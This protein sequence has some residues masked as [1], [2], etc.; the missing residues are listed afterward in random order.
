MCGVN[1][2]ETSIERALGIQ[3]C[4][5]SDEFQFCISIPAKPKTRR[6]ILST[7]ASIYDPMGYI[8]P[9]TLVG[10]QILQEMCRENMAWDE[11]LSEHLGLRWD[12]WL[13]DLPKLADIKIQRH[14]EPKDF[15]TIVSRELHHF[16]DASFS[17][18]GQC[19][20]LRLVNDRNEVFCIL[21]MGKSR[22]RL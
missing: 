8:A 3:W 4:V 18:Y 22:D 20:Y 2:E 12:R 9:F 14:V 13:L 7:V 6:G 5:S 15:G 16:S 1:L 11:P 21:M 19:S 17:G 10:K